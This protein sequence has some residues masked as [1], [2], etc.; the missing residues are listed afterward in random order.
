MNNYIFTENCSS[1]SHVLISKLTQIKCICISVVGLS[2]SSSGSSFSSIYIIKYRTS[3][4]TMNL[5]MWGKDGQFF[6]SLGKE[7]ML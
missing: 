5:N 6:V 1:L 2:T 4:G 7:Y 3:S